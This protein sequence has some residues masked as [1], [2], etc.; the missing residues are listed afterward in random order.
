LAVDVQRLD[1]LVVEG[2]RSIRHLDLALRP[3]NVLIGAN[4]SGKS[5][6][7]EVFD[8]L[9][10]IHTE[11]LRL[12]TARAGGAEQ[13]LHWGRR[14]TRELH[15]RVEVGDNA[16]EARLVADDRGG[17]FFSRER[18]WW[19]DPPH[20]RPFALGLGVGHVESKLAEEAAGHGRGA[21]AWAL[22]TLGS[23]RRFHFHDTSPAARVNQPQPLA[24][25]VELA[26]DAGNLGPFL[27]ALKQKD[28]AAY[29][30]IRDAVRLVAPFFDDFVLEPDDLNPEVLRLAWRHADGEGR[31]GP[32]ALSDGTLRFM[33]LAALLLQPSPPSLVVI[34]EPELG[35]HP[36]AIVQLADLLRST[37]STAQV[38]VATQS[39]TLLNNLDI[40]DVIVAERHGGTSTFTQVDPA[41][42]QA[43]LKDFAVG[44]LWEKNILGGRPA[45]T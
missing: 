14:V 9:G 18:C 34:D 15:L 12:F 44:E 10:A 33:C 26:R 27:W 16:Y 31:W 30:R 25:R 7:L 2:Y 43:W 13:L 35:L 22:A 3:M 32:E 37:A 38:I 24:D 29:L 42:L 39:V 1:R 28:A 23:W 41:S 20:D 11:Q 36:A 17:L 8:L 45:W 6:L 40:G 5:N 21:A 4:G 19:Q